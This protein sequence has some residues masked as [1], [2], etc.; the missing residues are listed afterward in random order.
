METVEQTMQAFVENVADNKVLLTHLLSH[1]NVDLEKVHVFGVSLGGIRSSLIYNLEPRIKSGISV[2]GGG[3]IPGILTYSKEFHVEILRE[4]F[5][6]QKNIKDLHELEALLRE[7][8]IFDPMFFSGLYSHE[9]RRFF[10]AIALKD[11]FVNTP[12]QWEFANSID[13]IEVLTLDMGHIRASGW[14][15]SNKDRFVEFFRR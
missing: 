14:A 5:M 9:G 1:H 2:I 13:N 4:R 7:K 12:Y 10:N 3:N 8:N 6:K 15:Y 11:T